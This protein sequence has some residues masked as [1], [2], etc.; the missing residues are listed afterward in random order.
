MVVEVMSR[1]LAVE[2]SKR[3]YQETCAMVSIRT[4]GVEMEYPEVRNSVKY[5]LPLSFA[6]VAD[7]DSAAHGITEEDAQK[8]A[9]FVREH[10]GKVDSFIVHCDAGVSRSAGVAAGILK[11]MTGR[12]DRIF[13]SLRYRP[14]MLCYRKVYAALMSKQPS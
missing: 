9:Q 6:D 4:P 11:V 3:D 2:Y 8:I 7:P 10:W 5:L 13:D 12:D 14:N 1:Q